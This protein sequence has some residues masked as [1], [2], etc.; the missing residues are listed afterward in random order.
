MSQVSERQNEPIWYF[1]NV[2]LNFNGY[3]LNRKMEQAKTS[4]DPATSLGQ[5]HFE[6]RIKFCTQY[7]T[8]R[9]YYG[10]VFRYCVE[11]VLLYQTHKKN[12]LL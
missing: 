8:K 12:Y 11:I 9:N 3:L 1:Q 6:L 5:S 10:R 7:A 2:R 4:C